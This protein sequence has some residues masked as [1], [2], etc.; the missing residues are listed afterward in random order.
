MKAIEKTLD[1]LVQLACLNQ[2]CRVC[3]K[4]AECGHHLIGRSNMML[5]YD[6]INIMPLCYDCHR[7]I[8]DGKINQWEYC[9]PEQKEFLQEKAKKMSYRDFLIFVAKQPEFEYLEGLKLFWRLKA[10]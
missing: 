3:G 6:A 8:H 1:K 7:K 4:P 5:R 10:K 9:A 2:K